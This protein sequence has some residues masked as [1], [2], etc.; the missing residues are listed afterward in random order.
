MSYGAKIALWLAEKSAVVE[1]QLSE[2]SS[3]EVEGK[4]EVEEREGERLSKYFRCRSCGKA[5]DNLGDMQKH[6]M[7]EHM[8]KGDIP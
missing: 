7:V 4:G 5:F 3:R 1:M 2:N 6:I 8:Q